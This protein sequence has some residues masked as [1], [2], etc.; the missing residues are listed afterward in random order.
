MAQHLTI[1][2]NWY[3]Q[4]SMPPPLQW[5]DAPVMHNGH[6]AWASEASLNGQVIARSVTSSKSTAQNEC[7]RQLLI[8]FRVPHN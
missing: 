7:A 6:S 3:R 8:H 1:W 5:S 2:Q 4:Q